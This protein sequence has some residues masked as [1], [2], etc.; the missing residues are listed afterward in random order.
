MKWKVGDYW[1]RETEGF[2]EMEIKSIPAVSGRFFFVI[3]L[4]D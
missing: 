2:H 4:N 1:L 3:E